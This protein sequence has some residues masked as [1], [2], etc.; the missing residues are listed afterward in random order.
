M[1]L[2]ILVI[3]EKYRD[4]LLE[5][6]QAAALRGHKVIL[7]FMDE[8]C[9]LLRDGEICSLTGLEGISAAVCDYNRKMA[10]I[11]DEDIPYGVTCGSQYDNAIMNRE[12]DRVIVL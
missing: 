7:F 2:G 6:A 1:T 8:G 3:T 9:N 10:G 5:T 12:A 4:K 11:A